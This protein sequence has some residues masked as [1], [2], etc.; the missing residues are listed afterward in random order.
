MNTETRTTLTSLTLPFAIRLPFAI[1]DH[2]GNA[3]NRLHFLIC[4]HPC[5]FL[6]I[7]SLQVGSGRREKSG[8]L[9]WSSSYSTKATSPHSSRLAAN[10]VGLPSRSSAV[11]V[12]LRIMMQDQNETFQ[13]R[14]NLTKAFPS[15]GG[16]NFVDLCGRK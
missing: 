1:Q 3:S 12:T 13:E 5:A 9:P 14:L 15:V 11:K 4:L 16:Q 7:T 6:V 10:K 8:E 2:A